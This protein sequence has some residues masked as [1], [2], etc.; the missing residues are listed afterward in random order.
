M[1]QRVLSEK[2]KIPAACR[3]NPMQKTSS[4][5]LATVQE[6]PKFPAL[7]RRLTGGFPGAFNYDPAAPPV[8]KEL[9][10]PVTVSQRIAHA[11][12]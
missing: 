8:H 12:R 11:G 2:S 3:N 10:G 7:V 5:H 4:T 1:L 9:G 6:H